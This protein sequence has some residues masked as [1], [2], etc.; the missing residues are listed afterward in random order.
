MK[1]FWNVIFGFAVK[2]K[3]LALTFD[4][5]PNPVFTPQI[6]HLLKKYDVRATFF[7]T[8]NKV[9]KHPDIVQ[10]AITDGHQIANHSYDHRN[11]LFRS[12]KSLR[13]DIHKTDVLLRSC[14]VEGN[15]PFRP[16]F[17]R[18]AFSLLLL[19]AKLQKKIIMWNIPTKDYKAKTCDQ[20]LQKVYQKVKPGGIIVMHDAG[21]EL[22]KEVD[23]SFTVLAL[24]KYLPELLK[25][26][27][28]FYTINELI[29]RNCNRSAR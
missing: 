25:Q 18:F 15:I 26:G 22:Q 4:D 20:I 1:G 3:I 17:G 5:G 27:Y 11:F 7:V 16:P 9:E 8:G 24:E 28:K 6:L 2:D 29:N 21:K 23:R 12:L 19:T 10:Q 14:G 13:E